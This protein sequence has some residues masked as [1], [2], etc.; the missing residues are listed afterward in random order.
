[1]FL[2]LLLRVFDNL[3]TDWT[4]EGGLYM[5]F[6]HDGN[7][8][9]ALKNS[10]A[11]SLED[12]KEKA[13]A[14]WDLASVLA[15]AWGVKEMVEPSQA[16]KVKQY[17]IEVSGT[18]ITLDSGQIVTILKGDIKEKNDEAILLYRYQLIG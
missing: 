7:I 18:N 11:A 13:C 2:I 9:K 10:I 3:S 4:N 5:L 6:A 12:R 16:S 8:E 1:M 14:T 17:I 15:H